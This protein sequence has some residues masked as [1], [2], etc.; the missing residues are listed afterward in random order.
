YW[1]SPRVACSPAGPLLAVG[2]GGDWWGA[3]DQTGSNVYL[4]DIQSGKELR[5]LSNAGDRAVF[6]SDGKRL[7]TANGG[8]YPKEWVVL[9]DVESGNRLAVLD[10]QSCV[11]GMAFSAD[12]SL[13]AIGTRLGEVTLWNLDDFSHRTLRE[14]TGD[15][16]RSVAFSPDGRWLAV[17]LAT[18]EV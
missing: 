8:R 14:A 18:Q 10:G 13:L 4:V 15:W 3:Y 7:A 17:A 2:T 1:K 11:L 6:S 5:T 12:G 9:W 16:A